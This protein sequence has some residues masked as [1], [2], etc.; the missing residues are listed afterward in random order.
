MHTTAALLAPRRTLRVTGTTNTAHAQLDHE[1]H[2]AAAY[3]GRWLELA[4]SSKVPALATIRRAL[5]FYADHL[6]SGKAD[7][8][9]EVRAVA[10]CSS[11]LRP[12]EDDRASAW[13]RLE[14]LQGPHPLIPFNDVLRGPG[15]AAWAQRMTAQAEAIADQ[16]MAEKMAHLRAHRK[17][18]TKGAA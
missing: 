9:N 3:A 6:S 12:A 18:S 5:I 14:A 13:A 2:L 1:A 8:A 7:P 16:L 11:S 10:R 4:G 15:S 17:S